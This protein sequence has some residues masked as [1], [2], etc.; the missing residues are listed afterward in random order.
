MALAK[1]LGWSA[2]QSAVRMV[3]GFAT[4]KVTAVYLGPAGL[5]IVGQLNN[6]LSLSTAATVNGVQTG[7]TKMTAE[8]G[9]DLELPTDVWSTGLRLAL[10]IAVLCGGAIAAGSYWLA[11]SLL[12]DENYWPAFVLAG[13]A[14]VGGALNGVF[15]GVL[16]GKRRMHA[17]AIGLILSSIATLVLSVP[18]VYFA[19]VTGGL[20]GC[21]LGFML[22]ALFSGHFVRREVGKLRIVFAGQFDWTIAHKLLKFYPMTL[23]NVVSSQLSLICVRYMLA[24]QL[25]LA[26][27]GVWQASQRLSDM[28]TAIIVQALSLFLMPHLSGIRDANQFRRELFGVS[29][30]AGALAI[31]IAAVIY[32]ARDLVILI[33]FTEKF[34]RMREL[35]AY[36]L[37]GDV[38]M[39]ACWPL[40]MG[41]VARVRVRQYI[42]VEFATAFVFVAGTYLLLP[43]IGLKGAPIA[44]LGS[45]AISLICLVV[46]HVRA[47]QEA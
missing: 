12:L 10:A 7:L 5:A 34:G 24:S 8:R 17:L 4:I 40:R 33:V 44:Y 30:K 35:F 9:T 42:S 41:L 23:S 38:L 3:V 31:V 6:F 2:A 19:G 11:G 13:V 27:A 47:R 28:Y 45:F 43:L 18:L 26:A 36:Q 39:V 32:L 15:N 46:L 20:I 25:G 22:T 29:L 1:A 14:V 16:N 37:L 21:A